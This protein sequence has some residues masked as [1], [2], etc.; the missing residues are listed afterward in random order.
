MNIKVNSDIG[1][2]PPPRQHR[3]HRARQSVIDSTEKAPASPYITLI[4]CSAP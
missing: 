4:F 1:Q 3:G 2:V